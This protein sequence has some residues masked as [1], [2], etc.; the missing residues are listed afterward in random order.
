[1]REWGVIPDPSTFQFELAPNDLFLTVVSDG[2]GDCIPS[3]TMVD[4]MHAGMTAAAERQS[5]AQAVDAVVA[6]SGDLWQATP[7]FEK[8]YVDDATLVAVAFTHAPP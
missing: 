2:I 4:R 5:L 7:G 8:T 6:S 3:Q 1:M